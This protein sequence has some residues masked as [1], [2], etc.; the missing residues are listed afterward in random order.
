MIETQ[1]VDFIGVPVRD[2]ARAAEFYEKTLGL[3]KNPHSTDDWIE[4]ETGSITL[5][6]VTPE[7][8]LGTFA[9]L[10]WGTIVLRVP[11]V[12][13]AKKTLREAGVQEIGDTWDS[14][15]CNGAPFVD[16]DGNGLMLHHRY[17]P[18]PDGREP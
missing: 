3:Q 10:P 12:E 13:E 14:G 2:R 6:L 15:V 1:R 5:A 18:Y 7:Q 17:K 9:P 8:V 11:N 16:P 4:F